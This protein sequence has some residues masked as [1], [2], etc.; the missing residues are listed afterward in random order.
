MYEIFFLY[1]G[2]EVLQ[3]YLFACKVKTTSLSVSGKGFY[4]PR[5]LLLQL[6]GRLS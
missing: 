1:T 4:L 6:F 5:T 3:R 2:R